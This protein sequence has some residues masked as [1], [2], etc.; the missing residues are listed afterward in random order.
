MNNSGR[1]K[2]PEERSYSPQSREEI[3]NELSCTSV[4]LVIS[5]AW[6]LI[7]SKLTLTAAAYLDVPVCLAVPMAVKYGL[8][9]VEVTYM[10][11]I[12]YSLQIWKFW[13]NI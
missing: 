6:C 3:K 8:V 11:H 5:M 2:V 13:D 12:R 7:N 10:L 9:T 4:P 1:Y